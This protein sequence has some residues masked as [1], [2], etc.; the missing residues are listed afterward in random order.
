MTDTSGSEPRPVA[1]AHALRRP[2]D[3]TRDADATAPA[4]DIRVYVDYL[5]T[6]FARLPAGE[7][8][9]AGRSGS[10]QDAATVSYYPVA[11]LT[12]KSNGTKYSLRAASAA[13]C[14]ATY[15]PDNFFAFNNA[16]LTQQP[17]VESD[18]LTDSQLADARHRVRRRRP[19]GR[20]RVHREPGVRHWAKDATDRALTG[21]AGYG[22]RRAHRHADDP[23]ERLAVRRGARRPQ[24]IRPVRADDRERRVLQGDGR[25]AHADAHRDSVAAVRAPG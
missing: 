5:S 18:G 2:A 9:A 11:M 7:R 19:Q 10:S 21:S 12:A 24:G 1:D 20:A 15:S 4:V 14:V 3:P 25:D 8:A 22:R 16:L 6:G 23:G 17:D 13:A